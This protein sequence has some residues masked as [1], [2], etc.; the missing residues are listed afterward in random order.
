MA[1]PSSAVAH[2]DRHRLDAI[3][4]RCG[5]RFSS[6]LSCRS[7]PDFRHSHGRTSAPEGLFPRSCWARIAIKAL[8]ASLETQRNADQTK[9]AACCRES[10]TITRRDGAYWDRGNCSQN[11]FRCSEQRTAS[12]RV[13]MTPR[14]T[15]K[16]TR[17]DSMPLLVSTREKRFTRQFSRWSVLACRLLRS[18]AASCPFAARTNTRRGAHRRGCRD[19]S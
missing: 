19:R 10:S 7:L 14:K 5:R 4:C 8:P 1:G 15:G 9:P 2:S 18:K 13:E 12:S 11:F 16:P 3:L 17:C 6:R